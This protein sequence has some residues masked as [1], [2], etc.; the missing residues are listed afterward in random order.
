MSDDEKE[1]ERPQD[2]GELPSTET[3]REIAW[4]PKTARR[5]SVKA[6]QYKKNEVIHYVFHDRKVEETAIRIRP[7]HSKKSLK[8]RKTKKKKTPTRGRKKYTKPR[9]RRT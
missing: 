9:V 8:K 5:K 6:E 1:E 7:R 4:Q 3:E 2:N